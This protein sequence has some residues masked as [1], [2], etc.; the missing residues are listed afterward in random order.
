MQNELQ[1]IEN[2]TKLNFWDE[3]WSHH[4]NL[5]GNYLCIVEW[6]KKI[7]KLLNRL[8]FIYN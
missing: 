3:G 2:P 1:M 8:I 6:E 4:P 5:R 7:Q